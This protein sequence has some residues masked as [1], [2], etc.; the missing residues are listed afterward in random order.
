MLRG[1]D[2]LACILFGQNPA[3]GSPNGKAQLAK[4]SSKLKWLVVRDFFEIDT[5]AFWYKGPENPD[6]CHRGYRGVLHARSLQQQRKTGTF[7]NTERLLQWHDK[8]ID[9]P[10]GLPV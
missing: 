7:T 8:A 5:A 4:R 1:Q 9:P 2:Q 3:A 10:G 6:P